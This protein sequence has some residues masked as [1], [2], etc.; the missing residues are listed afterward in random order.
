MYFLALS[1]DSIFR[2]TDVIS[3]IPTV[4]DDGG[5]ESNVAGDGTLLL[6][7]KLRDRRKMR[8]ALDRQHGRVGRV[9]G[10][11][12]R[13]RRKQIRRYAAE[14]QFVPAPKSGQLESLL[15]AMPILQMADERPPFS[16]HRIAIAPQTVSFFEPRVDMIRA[17][18]VEEIFRGGERARTT[19]PFTGEF[20][21]K[22]RRGGGGSMA[23]RHRR[24]RRDPGR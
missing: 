18:V 3:I 15:V 12:R 24:R 8:V 11:L 7:D 21:G 4:A 9:A 1:I 16:A 5:S 23:R 6:V 22:G 19:T 10:M 17:D 13:R 20:L 14:L 2:H